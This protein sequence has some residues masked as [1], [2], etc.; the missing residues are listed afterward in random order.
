[1]TR[2]LEGAEG[3]DTTTWQP[4]SQVAVVCAHVGAIDRWNRSRRMTSVVS[5]IAAESREARLD[6]PRRSD[7]LL[8]PHD[9]VIAQAAV[10]LG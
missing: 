2:T 10:H 7:V 1:M 8:R 6:R 9:A 5:L 3:V 4:R